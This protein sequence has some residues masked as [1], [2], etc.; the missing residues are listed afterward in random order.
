MS[1]G[2][3]DAFDAIVVELYAVPPAEF[4][5]ARAARAKESGERAPAVRA[6]RKP[7]VAAW[8]VDLMA[9]EQ[10]LGDA[11][12]LAAELRAA[13]DERDA[14]ELARLGTQ[15]RRLVAAL[16]GEAA[17]LAAERGVAVS[18][19]ARA[20]IEQT[21]NAAMI[22]AAA[23]AAV[24]SGRLATAITATGL[25][26]LDLAGALGGSVPKAPDDAGGPVD[27]AERRARKAAQQAAE[28]KREAARA[29]E[30]AR[31]E[32]ERFETERARAADEL[33]RLRRR[34]DE[35]RGEL[36]AAAARVPDL[37]RRVEELARA[38]A[39]TAAAAA[40]RE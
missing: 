13:Q 12:S 9:R 27:L 15:R 6:L 37:E 5:A 22:D 3:G 35:L 40:R 14:G 20:D 11:L 2:T 29:A 19:S 38:A 18:V 8:A 1:G 17:D 4:T 7:T 10:R 33:D 32:A 39:A 25:G 36:D 21:L 34:I 23:A 24:A 16:A 30:R 31:R 26:D 28:A